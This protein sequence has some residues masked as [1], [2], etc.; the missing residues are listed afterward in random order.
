MKSCSPSDSGSLE[1]TSL[2]LPF[3]N[4]LILQVLMKS[5]KS[6]NSPYYLSIELSIRTYLEP[7]KRTSSASEDSENGIRPPRDPRKKPP[8][9]QRRRKLHLVAWT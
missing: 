2:D 1:V 6:I 3:I 8:A 5:L 7:G 4:K 9:N